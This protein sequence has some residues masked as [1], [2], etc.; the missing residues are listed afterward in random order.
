[1]NMAIGRLQVSVSVV[2]RN[3]DYRSSY[4]APARRDPV[5]QAYNQQQLWNEVDADR[6][7]WS[8]GYFEGVRRL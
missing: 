5:E 2:E 3:A 8:S 1:M 7:R 4:P 6:A